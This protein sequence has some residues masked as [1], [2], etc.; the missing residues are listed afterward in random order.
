MREGAKRS[1]ETCEVTFVDEARVNRARARL[2]ADDR[3]A[4]LSETFKVLGEEGRVKL[5]LALSEEELCVCDLANLL[6]MSSSAVSHQLR[7]LRNLR[8]VRSRRVG[9]MA[10]YTLDDD[11]I[12]HLV[13]VGLRHIDETR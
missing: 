11:H 4:A 9:K 3:I 1:E 8:L 13:E 2:P 12:R 6:G 5:L 10:Y 7:L